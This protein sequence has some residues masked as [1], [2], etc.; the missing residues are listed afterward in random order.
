M[1][2][3]RSGA[4]GIVV[5]FSFGFVTADMACKGNDRPNQRYKAYD[6]A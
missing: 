4:D 1:D 2:L 5:M 6:E 3:L